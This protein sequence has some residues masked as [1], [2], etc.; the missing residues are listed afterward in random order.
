MKRLTIFSGLLLLAAISLPARADIVPFERNYDYTQSIRTDRYL[1]AEVWTDDNSYYQ[2][3]DIAISFRA[4]NDCYVAIYNLDTR[5]NVNLLYPTSPQDDGFIRGGKIYRLPE[6]NDNYQLS[7]QGPV[8]TEY[9]QIVASREPLR[10]PDWFNGSGLVCNDDP[11]DFIDYVN[12][13]YFGCAY[14]DCP[15]AFDITSFQVKEWHDY[16]FRPVY[17]YNYPDWSYC[18]SIYIDY[19]IGATVYI[20]GIYWGC[21]PLFIPRI[22][23]GYHWVTIYDHFG[24]C[25][26]SHVDVVRYRSVILDNNIVRTRAGVKSRYREVA[27]RG[28]LNP[29]RNG[30]PEYDKQ[31]RLKETYKESAIRQRDVN[32]GKETRTYN[33][34]RV[35]KGQT[36]VGKERTYESGRTGRT[37]ESTGKTYERPVKRTYESNTQ[38]QTTKR[39]NYQQFPRRQERS[40]TGQTY[41]NRGRTTTQPTEQRKVEGRSEPQRNNGGESQGTYREKPQPQQQRSGGEERRVSQPEKQSGQSSGKSS[42]SGERG[43]G[44]K[45]RR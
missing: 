3:D 22:Y 35:T 37:Y 14:N 38:Q 26:E 44:E 17:H 41:E 32:I 45:K 27:T 18:G 42:G 39:Q 36:A 7:V 5:G 43:G 28:Y 34:G 20:D 10:I 12:A 13:S 40:T 24:Y 30:Y 31:V 4:N 29:V 33:E 8:G 9:I 16:Y 1:N 19:P 2:G 23:F 15:R 21:A 11:E 6:R 25:W